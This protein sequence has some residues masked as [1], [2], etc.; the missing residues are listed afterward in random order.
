MKGILLLGALHAFATRGQLRN[1]AYYAGS[2]IG[3]MIVVLLAVGYEPLELLTV[4]CDPYFTGQFGALNFGNLGSL[5]GLFPHSIMRT[6]LEELMLL[7]LGYLP[8]LGDLLHRLHKH[9]IIT[10]YCLSESDPRKCKVYFDPLTHPDVPV[11]DAVILSC[12]IPGIFQRAKWRD[13]IW[14]DGACTSLLPIAALQAAAPP[15]CPILALTLKPDPA[16][17]E[18]MTGYF[19]SVISIPFRDQDYTSDLSPSTDVIEIVSEP[20][21]GSLISSLNFASGSRQKISMFTHA[22]KQVQDLLQHGALAALAPHTPD[23]RPR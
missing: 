11:V 18:T 21:T 16:D 22:V 13:K 17:L 20:T 5:M 3:A 23:L 14:I 2:S 8:T 19:Y 7:K 10:E 6:K 12:S 9:V 1:L 4:I 15:Q